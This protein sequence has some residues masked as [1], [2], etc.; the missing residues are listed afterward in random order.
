M[1]ASTG[2]KRVLVVVKRSRWLPGRPTIFAALAAVCGVTL[3]YLIYEIHDKYVFSL[4]SPVLVHFRSPLVIAHRERNEYRRLAQADQSHPLTAYQEY[5]CS[6]F[7]DACRVALAIQRAENPAGKC[8]VYH[9][10]SDGSLDWGY[11]QINTVHLRRPGVVLR[12]LLDCKANIDF[13]YELYQ[14]RHGFSAWAAYNSG[15]Y[16]RYL[17]P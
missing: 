3:T 4:Q 12:N 10:N 15:K 2:T 8:E 16:R 17:R 11:F 6:K 5:T 7:G 14:E 13:A 9:Y 1:G